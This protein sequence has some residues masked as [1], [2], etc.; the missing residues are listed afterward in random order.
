MKMF[1]KWLSSI[2]VLLILSVGSFY[3]LDQNQFF[4]VTDVQIL[5]EKDITQDLKSKDEIL[6]IHKN[7]ENLKGQPIY[8]L[9]MKSIH[10]SL[11]Q[12][13]WIKSFRIHRKWPSSV[14]IFLKP[15][16]I[17]FSILTQTGELR[18][19]IQ[20]GQMLP[21][22]RV[23]NAPD[24]PLVRQNEFLNNESLRIRLIQLLKDIPIRG[25][26]SRDYISEVQYD[27]STGF[28][29]LM[30][31]DNLKV[32]LGEKQIRNKSLQ[33]KQVIQYLDSKKIQARVIDANLSQKV[34]VRL[35]KD[36]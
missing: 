30:T 4:N 26:F 21:L 33:V 29:L 24:V 28:T 22:T 10:S 14:Q 13:L 25:E 8:N 12:E 18:P 17:Y 20:S 32:H 15:E 36:P 7:F 27:Q 6:R 19:V 11:D 2:L 9:N 16:P 35:R 3:L 34:L 5:I 31:R 23:H 1:L